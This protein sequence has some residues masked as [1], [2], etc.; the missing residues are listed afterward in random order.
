MGRIELKKCLKVFIFLV[1]LG[2][3]WGNS[4]EKMFFFKMKNYIYLGFR[5]GIGV[6]MFISMW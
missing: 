5:L 1:S 3:L 2:V 4:V 6:N